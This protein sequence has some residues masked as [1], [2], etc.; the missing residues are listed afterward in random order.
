[1]EE[2]V[3]PDLAPNGPNNIRWAH[4]HIFSDFLMLKQK[5]RNIDYR[6]FDEDLQRK[7]D[8]ITEQN[9][10]DLKKEKSNKRISK[11]NMASA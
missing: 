3:R 6:E 7:I 4:E 11:N 9:L 8:E 1:M 2:N 10:A 5:F